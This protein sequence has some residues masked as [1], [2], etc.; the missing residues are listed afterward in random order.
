MQLA[1][2]A[3]LSLPPSCRPPSWYAGQFLV[4]TRLPNSSLS[5]SPSVRFS[6]SRR[7]RASSAHECERASQDRN[8]LK[9]ARLGGTLSGRSLALCGLR[10]QG[11]GSGFRFWVF[12]SELREE[13]DAARQRVVLFSMFRAALLLLRRLGVHALTESC[14]QPPWSASAYH[15]RLAMQVAVWRRAHTRRGF[16]TPTPRL[17]QGKAKAVASSAG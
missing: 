15:L 7:M 5:L 16:T 8:V 11:S 13:R 12:G 1:L 6:P 14:Q 4:D 10:V 9:V 3:S 17:L 2:L